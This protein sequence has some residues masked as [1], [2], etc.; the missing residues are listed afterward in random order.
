MDENF[1]INTTPRKPREKSNSVAI[2]ALILAAAALTISVLGYGGYAMFYRFQGLP[3]WTPFNVIPSPSFSTTADPLPS[4]TLAN[5]FVVLAAAFEKIENEELAKLFSE[6][7]LK[8]IGGQEDSFPDEAWQKQWFEK[9]K[10]LIRKHEP[11]LYS[12]LRKDKV[13]GYLFD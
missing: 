5:S 8:T 13:A 2:V 6:H 7:T 1:N 10:P 11:E 9:V 12:K 4:Y 3:F